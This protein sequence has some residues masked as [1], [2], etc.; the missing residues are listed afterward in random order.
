MDTGDHLHLEFGQPKDGL[1][2]VRKNHI[3][4]K[5]KP[6]SP[7][8]KI[9]VTAASLAPSRMAESVQ[10]NSA[11]HQSAV[12]PLHHPLNLLTTALDKNKEQQRIKGA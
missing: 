5:T 12:L 11:P 3:N 9:K 7:E 8:K 10:T 6:S 4:H 1:R 2:Y